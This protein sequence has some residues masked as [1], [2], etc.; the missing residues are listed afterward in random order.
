MKYTF[1]TIL[2]LAK[3]LKAMN[4][5]DPTVTLFDSLFLKKYKRQ[6]IE[7]LTKS[8]FKSSIC[9]IKIWDRYL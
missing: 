3:L 4:R 5:P 6:G 7:I 8:L 2:G 9:A 1:M